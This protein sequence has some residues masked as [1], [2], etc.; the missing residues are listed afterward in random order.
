MAFFKPLSVVVTEKGVVVKM[1]VYKDPC[2]ITVTFWKSWKEKI[3]RRGPITTSAE[4]LSPGWDKIPKGLYK[5]LF[6]Q[7]AAIAAER[8]KCASHHLRLDI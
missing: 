4:H 1:E 6:K 8:E 7:A 5:K 3:R 2:P